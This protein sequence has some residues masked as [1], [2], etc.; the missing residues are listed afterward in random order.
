M[1]KADPTALPDVNQL[2][3]EKLRSYPAV[4]SELAIRAI[5]LSEDLPEATVFEMLQ[6]HIREASRKHGGES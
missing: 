3:I 2:I 6:G 1:S 4:V 5:Q